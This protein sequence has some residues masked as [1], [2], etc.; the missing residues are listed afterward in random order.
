MLAR[1]CL[2]SVFFL[3]ACANES[4]PGSV[5]DAGTTTAD[6]SADVGVGEPDVGEPSQDEGK[7]INW[8]DEAFTPDD[9]VDD[10]G[11]ALEEVN[12]VVDDSGEALEEVNVVECEPECGEF[13]ICTEEGEC[14]EP[15]D[16]AGEC[17]LGGAICYCDADGSKVCPLASICKIQDDGQGYCAA[18]PLDV[19]ECPIPLTC[20]EGACKQTCTVVD[21][22]TN[23]FD[24]VPGCT[25]DGKVKEP[26]AECNAGFCNYV[27]TITECPSGLSCNNGECMTPCSPEG[28][29]AEGESY[30]TEDGKLNQSQTGE[31]MDGFCLLGGVTDC[32]DGQHC[33]GGGC[34]EVCNSGKD[35]GELNSCASCDD[36]AGECTGCSIF[37]DCSCNDA[38]D[39]T[40]CQVPKCLTDPSNSLGYC[41]L[42]VEEFPCGEWSTCDSDW[43][44]CVLSSG[45]VIIEG[46]SAFVQTKVLA[47]TDGVILGCMDSYV[48]PVE[49]VII[50]DLVFDVLGSAQIS[51]EI[52]LRNLDTGEKLG[53]AILSSGKLEFSNL[54]WK[55][56]AE[57]STL[58]HLV[59][60]NG[61]K[62]SQVGKTVKFALNTEATD[63]IGNASGVKL[64][65]MEFS[66][67]DLTVIYP[68][69]L[70]VVEPLAIHLING[71]TQLI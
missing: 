62:A 18:G 31:C 10:S 65:V 23:G 26:S 43:G 20:S 17:S 40:L 30:C 25:D 50:D 3:V 57:T 35:C 60:K 45:G 14:A 54:N 66:T 11:E 38:G 2:I 1:A 37:Q 21:D 44:Q 71:N 32:P 4:E 12:V 51:S 48:V 46:C 61:I 68:A 55:L 15:C 42:D 70:V 58:L 13:T 9:V 39:G 52:E 27:T 28:T 59:A 47:E 29:C 41:A 69:I 56:D 19:S 7:L 64:N 36:E 33:A 24:N 5:P 22:C 67:T 53:S 16:N 63:L 34:T 6:A 8:T 49:D